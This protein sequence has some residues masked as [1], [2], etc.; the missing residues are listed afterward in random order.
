MLFEKKDIAAI[1]IVF[2]AVFGL[3]NFQARFALPDFAD[4]TLVRLA[5][6]GKDVPIHSK[7]ASA[8]LPAFALLSGSSPDSPDSIV[9]LLLIISPLLLSLSAVFLY[10]ALRMAGMKKTTSAFISLL[11]SFLL[12]PKFLAGMYGAGQLA[13]FFFSLFLFHFLMFRQRKSPGALLSSALHAS[14]SAFIYPSSSAAIMAVCISSAASEKDGRLLHLLPAVSLLFTAFST[15]PFSFSLDGA[16]AAPIILLFAFALLPMALFAAGKSLSFDVF[17]SALGLASVPA[18]LPCAAFALSVPAAAGIEE[19]SKEGISKKAKL[20]AALAFGFFAAFS[21]VYS[22]SNAVSAAAISF[23]LCFLFPL[24]MHL[25]DYQNAKFFAILSLFFFLF[26]LFSF[27]LGSMRTE[28]EIDRD[29][30]S[31]FSFLSKSKAASGFADICVAG[32]LEMA[33]FYLPNSTFCN[34]SSFLSFL[35]NGSHAPKKG[36]ILLLSPSYFESQEWQAKGGFKAYRFGFNFTDQNNGKYALFIGASDLVFRPVDLE[37]NFLLKDGTLA[38]FSLNPYAS[39]PYSRM[40]LLR[41][42]LPF[43]SQQN[44]LLVLQEGAKPPFAS[45][46]YAGKAVGISKLSEFG[47]VAIYEVN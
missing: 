41:Q 1:L 18:C 13:A 24:A 38:D 2:I 15:E 39:V 11:A 12:A 34:Q 8:L 36:S 44:R 26:A 35:A 7:S 40:V 43:Y 23:M 27:V 30:A 4:A 9:G 10:L 3:I 31:A 5:H 33:R 32:K 20:A 37:G 25:Y 47:L 42:D 46:I 28:S 16:Q 21:S 45:K 19:S 22:G 14:I 6:E 17:L 29:F